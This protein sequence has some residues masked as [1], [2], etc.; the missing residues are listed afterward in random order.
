MAASYSRRVGCV[1]CLVVLLV[2]V[3]EWD[4]EHSMAQAHRVLV[5]ASEEVKDWARFESL[6]GPS[7]EGD[8]IDD[9]DEGASNA[10]DD[11]AVHEDCHHYEVRVEVYF[12]L[13]VKCRDLDGVAVQISDRQFEQFLDREVTPRFPQGFSVMDVPLGQ[14]YS[15][16]SRSITK[17]RSKVMLLLMSDTPENHRKLRAIAH[18]Y[19][20][21]FHQE[22]VM[23][24][25]SP[26]FSHC[27]V[28]SSAP[29][30]A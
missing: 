4:D 1:W 14:W 26:L 7:L 10:E 3:M 29:S 6:F 17:E 20:S 18:R 15:H 30:Q 13:D 9:D 25:K 19:T 27:F 12:G 24:S 16:A 21:A 11:L 22:T 8:L 23:I 2:L 28:G 5:L